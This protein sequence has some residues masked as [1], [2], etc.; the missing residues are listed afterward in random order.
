MLVSIN[1]KYFQRDS[2]PV[3]NCEEL[4][5]REAE[6]ERN[7]NKIC[8][9]AHTS[10]KP[11]HKHIQSKWVMFGIIKSIQYRDNL[12]KKLKMSDHLSDE[13]ATLKINLNSYL[14]QYIKK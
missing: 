6:E 2:Y 5:K 11:S 12:C 3:K 1:Y 9:L 8:L 7:L 14:Q 13:F 4:L 10:P